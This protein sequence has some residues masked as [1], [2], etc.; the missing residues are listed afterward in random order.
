M[1]LFTFAKL[2]IFRSVNM[3]LNIQSNLMLTLISIALIN[4]SSPLRWFA[5]WDFA[6]G[7]SPDFVPFSHNIQ[8]SLQGPWMPPGGIHLYYTSTL[9]RNKILSE[10]APTITSRGPWAKIHLP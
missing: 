10:A 4:L 8:K 6:G 3:G 2:M 5:D 7:I 1:L 9:W